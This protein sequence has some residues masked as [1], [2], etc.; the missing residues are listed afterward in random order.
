MPTRK[1]NV[2]PPARIPEPIAAGNGVHAP[3][4]TGAT[5]AAGA[6]GA[7]EPTSNQPPTKKDAAPEGLVRRLPGSAFSTNATAAAVE[8]GKF[9][10]L[11]APNAAPTPRPV[12]P[13]SDDDFE[14]DDEQARQRLAMLNSL[15]GG[16]GKGRETADADDLDNEGDWQ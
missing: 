10:R 14:D 9:R 2:A 7:S 8:Q 1:P 15:R 6:T 3:A 16:V 13:E 12:L 5:G 11:P 4:K